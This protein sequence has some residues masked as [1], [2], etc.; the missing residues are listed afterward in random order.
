[1]RL[2]DTASAQAVD[3]NNNNSILLWTRRLHDGRHAEMRAPACLP[4]CLA[5]PAGLRAQPSL[6]SL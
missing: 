4:A 2:G 3:S 5:R 1:M 6:H